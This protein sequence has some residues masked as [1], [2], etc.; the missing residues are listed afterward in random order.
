VEDAVIEA[1]RAHDALLRG[2]SQILA[3][4]D[5]LDTQ[6]A[7]MEAAIAAL[8]ELVGAAPEPAASPRPAA[9]PEPAAAPKPTAAPEP[10]ASSQN[11]VP[12]ATTKASSPAPP[13]RRVVQT[14]KP[15]NRKARIREIMLEAPDDWFT[16]ADMAPRVEHGDPSEMRRTATYEMMRRMAKQG[17]LERDNS[18]RPTRFRARAAAIRERLLADSQ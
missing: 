6:L 15:V 7:R 5:A 18:S 2:R 1:R 11:G 17:E 9:A 12:A 16:A 8:R 14:L 13:V 3:Q 4:R 10:T